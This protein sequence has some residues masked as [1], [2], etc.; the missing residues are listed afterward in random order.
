MVFKHSLRLTF[1]K[2]LYYNIYNIS[3]KV[4]VLE[5]SAFWRFDPPP[6]L[7]CLCE[8]QVSLGTFVFSSDP[9]TRLR[10]KRRR[11]WARLSRCCLTHT[12]ISSLSLLLFLS[13]AAHVSLMGKERKRQESTKIQFPGLRFN[14]HGV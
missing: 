7:H 14:R 4:N 12:R 5:G 2:H 3:S 9:L 8:F 11:W 6:S 10:M 13:S 1:K